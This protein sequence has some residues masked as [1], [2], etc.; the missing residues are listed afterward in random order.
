METLVQQGSI[1][2]IECDVAVVN[3]FRGVKFPGGA[4]G[5]V[6]KALDGAITEAIAEAEFEGNLGD[7]LFLP[8]EGKVSAKEVLVIGLGDSAKFDYEAVE[9]VSQAAISAS[10]A[11]GASTV[12]TIIHGGGIGG[13][14]MIQSAK[15]I[16][17][18]SDNG[19]KEHGCETGKLIIAVFD[20]EKVMSVEKSLKVSE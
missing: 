1:T 11:K 18:G 12:A 3:L 15:A 4:T 17:K 6:D 19:F 10:V 2:D 16:V 5:A 9:K 8:G 20:P 14:D 7:T 13:L